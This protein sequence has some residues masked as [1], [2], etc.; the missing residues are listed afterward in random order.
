M[1]RT[2]VIHFTSVHP[3]FDVRIFH[4]E[5]KSLA[6]A[7]YDVRLLCCGTQDA[8]IDDV[9]IRVI[10]KPKN[11][12][13][14]MTASCI[15]LY[16]QC[17]EADADIYHFHDPELLG[18]GL[19]L[20]ARGKTVI[21]DVHEDVPKNMFSKSYLP[22]LLRPTIARAAAGLEGIACRRFSALVAATPA[23]G[24]RMDTLNRNTIVVQNFP[25]VDELKPTSDHLSQRPPLLV[26]AGVIARRRGL[27]EMIAAMGLLPDSLGS[28][29]V[30]AGEFETPKERLEAS[31][32]AGWGRIQEIG[33]LNRRQINELLSRAR[34][35]LVLY[36]PTPNHVRAGPH[37]LF[38]CMA[39]GMPVIASDF[40][41]WQRVIQ[42]NE[43]G[44]VVNPLD[45]RAIANSI[46]FILTHPAE[47]DQMGR[48][49]RLAAEKYYNWDFEAR[50]LLDLYS[51]LVQKPC[52]A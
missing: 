18:I 8:D 31:R 13:S 41:S 46:E 6:K 2:K 1:H 21:Y 5:C 30:L 33:I 51:R 42:G 35:G 24:E 20:R 16:R 14:R 48:N 27:H 47:A 15:H 10:G 23:I 36:H 9:Q 39:A 50:K 49:A 26:Y 34:I 4:K 28:A 45:P 19:L 25:V 29:L 52:A 37:K 12:L 40:P 22:S 17:V 38:E 44:F 3:P 11:R 43:C 7:G 32:L